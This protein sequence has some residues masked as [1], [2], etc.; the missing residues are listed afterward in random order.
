VRWAILAAA[1]AAAVLMVFYVYTGVTAVL[2][3][4]NA[5]P[6]TAAA[7]TSAPSGSPAPSA[8]TVAAVT[9][10]DRAQA[11]GPALPSISTFSAD[12]PPR[13]RG[14]MGRILRRRVTERLSEFR[15]RLASCPDSREGRLGR[16]PSVLILELL[17]RDGEMEVVGV[18]REKHGWA[19][20]SFLACARDVLRGRMV[21]VDGAKS[22]T[23][24]HLAFHLGMQ[25]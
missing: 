4:F 17:A 6:D 21:P 16:A 7:V 18:P 5:V 11:I 14:A 12:D 25:D 2:S 1:L 15:P 9:S 24:M 13:A 3:S 22:G 23:R 20:E 10:G 19:T 8:T